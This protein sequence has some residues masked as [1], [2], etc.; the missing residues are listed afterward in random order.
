MSN[1]DGFGVIEEWLEDLIHIVLLN[2]E[3]I[4]ILILFLIKNN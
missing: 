1:N 4:K 2:A 3:L